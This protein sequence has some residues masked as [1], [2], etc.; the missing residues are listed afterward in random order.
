MPSSKMYLV[1]FKIFDCVQYCGQIFLPCLN[2]QIYN[3]KYHFWPWSKKF[4]CVQNIEQG[5]KKFKHCQ[6][7]SELADGIGIR[8]RP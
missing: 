5:Q 3:V 4:E 2:M 7:I 6:N 1:A 8:G